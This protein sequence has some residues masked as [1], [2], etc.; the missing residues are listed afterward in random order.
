MNVPA[1]A[2][3]TFDQFKHQTEFIG[4]VQ[5]A[6]DHLKKL[7]NPIL[8]AKFVHEAVDEFNQEVFTHPL[9]KQYSP[10]TMGC[11]A[12]CHTQVSVTED[13][14]ILLARIVKQGLPIDLNQLQHQMKAKDDDSEYY[15]MPFAERKC[16]F[17]QEDGACGVYE[18]RPS[19]CRTN[20]VIGEAAQCDTTN[21]VG[22][23]HLIKTPKADMIIY[24]SF[25]HAKSSG[26][27]PHMV[28]KA[29]GLKV[30]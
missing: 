17:L 23:T 3:R 26:A 11:S 19:V 7:T 22:K 27:L 15:K 1:I 10:C 9:V 18:D 24:A 30:S 13:E 6:L 8:R 28:A 20:A 21:G 29:L 25:Y 14:A 16:I 12:C 5:I 2:K 4:I